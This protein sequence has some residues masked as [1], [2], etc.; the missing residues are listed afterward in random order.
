[1]AT[2]FLGGDYTQGVSCRIWLTINGDAARGTSSCTWKELRK[3][4]S[5]D[6]A[7]DGGALRLTNFYSISRRVEDSLI[8]VTICELVLSHQAR[9]LY[10]A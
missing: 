4:T 3:S 2:V 5:A 7:Y 10:F 8:G 6:G 9:V 1:M